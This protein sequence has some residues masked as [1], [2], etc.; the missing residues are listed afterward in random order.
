MNSEDPELGTRRKGR[1]LMVENIRVMWLASHN[2]FVGHP[3][4]WNSIRSQTSKGSSHLN[5]WQAIGV[6]GRVSYRTR[7]GGTEN[8]ATRFRLGIQQLIRP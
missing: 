2:T 5:L 6:I 4:S 7:R 8:V 1:F 3:S